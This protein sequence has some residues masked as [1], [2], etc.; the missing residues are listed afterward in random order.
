MCPDYR[1]VLKGILHSSVQYNY[2]Y[3]VWCSL[4]IFFDLFNDSLHDLLV[5]PYLLTAVSCGGSLTTTSSR[6]RG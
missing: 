2:I 6:D 5:C 3:N 1:G 4:L